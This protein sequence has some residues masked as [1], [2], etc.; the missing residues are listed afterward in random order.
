MSDKI[1]CPRCG[2]FEVPTKEGPHTGMFCELC[3][4]AERHGLIDDDDE[5]LEVDVD[6]DGH[7]TMHA[8]FRH[9]CEHRGCAHVVQ[10]DDEPYCFEHSPDSGSSV[11]GY[12][13]RRAAAS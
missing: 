6:L 13:A 2:A 5:V 11:P 10:Y 4:L 8:I 9:K 1:T 7:V 3:A 12:S